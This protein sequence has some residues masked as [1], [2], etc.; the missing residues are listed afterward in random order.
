MQ[1]SSD[2]ELAVAVL[3]S[4]HHNLG[5]VASDLATTPEQVL[6]RIKRPLPFMD[7]D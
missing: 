1:N 7:Q 2:T 6:D 3:E 5:D 4:S